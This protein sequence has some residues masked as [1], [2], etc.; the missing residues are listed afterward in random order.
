MG[1]SKII[2]TLGNFI[3]N[4]SAHKILAKHTNKPESL[5]HLLNEIDAYRDSASDLAKRF[6]WNSND[7][8]RIREQALKSLRKELKK[9]HFKDVSY[10]INEINPTIEKTMKEVLVVDH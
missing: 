7:K 10:P 3:G 5:N 9:E 8:N 4:V 2:K 6:N 1:K